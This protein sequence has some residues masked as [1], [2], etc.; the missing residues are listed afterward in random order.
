MTMV[1][2]TFVQPWPWTKTPITNRRTCTLEPRPIGRLCT[3]VV[4]PKATRCRKQR[5]S[6]KPASIP[7]QLVP[8]VP[9]VSM[10][11]TRPR[12]TISSTLRMLNVRLPTSTTTKTEPI[13]RPIR[14][15]H[16]MVFVRRKT[17]TT[18]TS[19]HPCRT[20]RPFLF[21]K[22]A[23]SASSRQFVH[24]FTIVRLKVLLTLP[25]KKSLPRIP[26][27]SHRRTSLSQTTKRTPAKRTPSE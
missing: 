27:T 17:S 2:G 22:L 14:L 7:I 6:L 26:A 18:D 16:A 4:T 12:V 19:I 5:R 25:R 15:R 24:A 1:Y 20:P 8:K 11:S 23:P 3:T 10:A 21:A 9:R 13:P